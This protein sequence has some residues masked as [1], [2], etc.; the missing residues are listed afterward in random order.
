MADLYSRGRFAARMYGYLFRFC[1]LNK[2]TRLSI[3]LAICRVFDIRS[4]RGLKI[5][6]ICEE[7]ETSSNADPHLH[8]MRSDISLLRKAAR[9]R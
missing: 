8:T 7:L 9:R 5:L 1:M 2:L 3:H 6:A 4:D